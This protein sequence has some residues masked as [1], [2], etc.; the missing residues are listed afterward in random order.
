MLEDDSTVFAI[1]AELLYR[2]DLEIVT[3]DLP[4][5]DFEHAFV[6]LAKLYVFAEKVMDATARSGLLEAFDFL[7]TDRLFPIEAAQIIYYG[8]LE[9]DTARATFVRSFLRDGEQD[10]LDKIRGTRHPELFRDL[11][12]SLIKQRSVVM[13]RKLELLWRR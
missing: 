13:E 3:G 4:Y 8:T 2:P 5:T 7:T 9:G 1:Y 12:F 6:V 11:A 10:S